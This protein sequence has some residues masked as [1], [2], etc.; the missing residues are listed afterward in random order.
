MKF[1]RRAYSQAIQELRHSL[2]AYDARAVEIF[3][4]HQSLLSHKLSAKQLA[5]I[6]QAI[7]R[8]DYDQAIAILDKAITPSDK[9][10]K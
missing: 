8:Y 2:G 1:D 5:D 10:K 7:A 4:S 3:Q 9:T 6:E